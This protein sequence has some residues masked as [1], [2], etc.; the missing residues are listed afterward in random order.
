MIRAI[1]RCL[2]GYAYSVKAAT[3]AQ[4]RTPVRHGRYL[5]EKKQNKKLR[6]FFVSKAAFIPARGSKN[7]GVLSS[8]KTVLPQEVI[9]W[10]VLEFV[11][12][13]DEPQCACPAIAC[14]ILN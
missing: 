13:H 6:A 8:E 12:Q 2:E 3:S 10:E 7:I 14:L 11:G 1:C 4:R 9:T 5:K